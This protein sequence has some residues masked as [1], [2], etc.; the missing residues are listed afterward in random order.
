MKII[1]ITLLAVILFI[2]GPGCRKVIDNAIGVYPITEME[3]TTSAGTTIRYAVAV[4]ETYAQG[5]STP[6]IVALHFG[7]PVTQSYGREFMELLVLPA[8]GSMKA[9]IVAPNLPTQGGWTT[10]TNDAAVLALVDRVMADYTID[11]SR[12]VVTGYSLGAIG[13]WHFAANY[14]DIFA[15][16]VPVSGMPEERSAALISDTPVY[17]IHSRQDEA[18]PFSEVETLVAQLQEKG[19]PV[20]LKIVENLFHYQT[21]DFVTYLMTAV[22]WIRQHW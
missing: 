12:I 21:G 22:Q 15:A 1:W 5:A 4:P 9:I 10:E 16:A 18:F 3:I 2:V 17:V 7:G 20:E 19:V 13:A 8:M 11:P 6:L 14:P